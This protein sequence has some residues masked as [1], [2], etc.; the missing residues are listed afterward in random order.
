MWWGHEFGWGWMIFG[1]LMMIA[2]WGGLI[3]LAVFVI[4]AISGSSVRPSGSNDSSRPDSALS[5]L[6][7]RYAR[8]EITKAEYEE[9]RRELDV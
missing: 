5:I 7:E 8:G 3:L 9:M 1:S 2:F 4:R 6:K